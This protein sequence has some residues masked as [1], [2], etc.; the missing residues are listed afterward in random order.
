MKDKMRNAI[1][2]AAV[3]A[4]LLFITSCYKLIGI[5][6]PTEVAPGDTFVVRMAVADDGSTTQNF[7]TDWSLAGIRVPDGWTVTVPKGAHRQYAEDWVYYSDGSQVASQQDMVA[8]D[9]LSELYE[10]ASAKRDYHWEAFSTTKPVAKHMTAC[11]R[12]GCDSIVITFLV[13][14]PETA[15]PGS[16]TLDFLAGDEEDANGIYKYKDY[17]STSGSRLFHVG[18][19][20]SLSGGR[21]VDN[22]ATALRRTVRVLDPDAVRAPSA[23]GRKSDAEVYDVSGR[24]VRQNASLRGLQRGMYIRG[25]KKVR[26]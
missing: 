4:L 15:E 20:S 11:W 13:T 8:D 7:T 23:D 2:Y 5:T 21:K 18:T 19:I 24:L 9:W 14:V 6:A 25:G 10:T 1:K 26:L 22:V 17:A 3:A 16:Y 12:N